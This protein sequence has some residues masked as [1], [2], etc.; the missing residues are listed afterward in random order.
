MNGRNPMERK[1]RIRALDERREQLEKNR[2]G[3]VSIFDAAWLR[4]HFSFC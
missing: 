2:T 4:P 3:D 1:Q